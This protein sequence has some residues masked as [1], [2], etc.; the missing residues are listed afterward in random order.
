MKLQLKTLLA[1]A[2]AAMSVATLSAQIAVDSK[3]ESV[4]IG[5][6]LGGRIDDCIEHRVKTEDWDHLVEPFRKR[7]ETHTWQSEFWGKWVQGAIASYRYNRDAELYDIIRQSAEA[8]MATQTP[9]GYIGTYR[10][11]MHLNQWDIWA[12]NILCSA[13][14]RGTTYRA[15]RRLLRRLAA[16]LST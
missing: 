6:Y 14:L 13:L 15:T 4:K 8:I 3:V 16:C 9:D 10:D 5:G 11:D 12:E 1:T 7:I 2:L